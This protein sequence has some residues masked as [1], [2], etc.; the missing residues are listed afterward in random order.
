MSLNKKEIYH[1]SI[2]S[3]DD[4]GAIVNVLRPL[5]RTKT[6]VLLKGNL[7]AGKTTLVQKICDSYGLQF[8]SSPTFSLHQVYSTEQITIDHFD[9]YRLENADDIETSGLWDVLAK[10]KAL[11]FIEWSERISATDLPR[12]FNIFEIE[13]VKLT[14]DQRFVRIELLEL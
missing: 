12:D 9:L 7:A 14:D 8:V 4:Y 13:I 10:S 2:R 6:C 11:V 1:G 5:F 3:L